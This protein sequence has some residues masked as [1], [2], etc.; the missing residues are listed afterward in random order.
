MRYGPEHKVEIDRKIVKDASRRV[1]AE[2]LSGAAV[3]AVIKRRRPDARRFLQAFR[4][5]ERPAFGVA[6]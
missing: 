1:G 3:S 6:P 2:G 5:Q 4:E